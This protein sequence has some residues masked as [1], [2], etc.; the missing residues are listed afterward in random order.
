MNLIKDSYLPSVAMAQKLPI[1]SEE[2]RCWSERI[3]DKNLPNAWF[4]SN[5]LGQISGSGLNPPAS[6]G[7]SK[8][9]ET[10]IWGPEESPNI[11]SYGVGC[12]LQVVLLYYFG[13]FGGNAYG[14]SEIA[15]M[16]RM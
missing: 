15:E 12:W 5:I 11:I 13:Q 16:W 9:N 3:L 14:P 6:D 2:P 8:H 1:I 10:C 7:M 4:R